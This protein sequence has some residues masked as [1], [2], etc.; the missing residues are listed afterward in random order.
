LLYEIEEEALLRFSD[1]PS[2]ALSWKPAKE[3][4]WGRNP[5][6]PFTSRAGPEENITKLSEPN[7]CYYMKY[8]R[9]RNLKC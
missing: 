5:Q 1:C 2:A 7:I 6:A 9:R 3:N 4:I 8:L